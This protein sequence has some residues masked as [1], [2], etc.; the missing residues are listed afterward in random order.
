MAKISYHEFFLKYHSITTIFHVGKRFNV[1][2]S[3]YLYAVSVDDRIIFHMHMLKYE[4]CSFC[5]FLVCVFDRH[6]L[7]SFRRCVIATASV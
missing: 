2:F 4:L 1:V 6:F 7:D 5:V 3:F